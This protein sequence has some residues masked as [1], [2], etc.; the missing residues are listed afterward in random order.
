MKWKSSTPP[1][2]FQP[3]VIMFWRGKWIYNSVI[4]TTLEGLRPYLQICVQQLPMGFWQGKWPLFWTHF[5]WIHRVLST[6]Q[7]YRRKLS[8]NTPPTLCF[9]P[10][11][12]DRSGC[13]FPEKSPKSPTFS[14]CFLLLVFTKNQ[15]RFPRFLV[16]LEVELPD[17]IPQLCLFGLRFPFIEFHLD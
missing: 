9:G 16:I 17:I 6:I 10:I 4:P 3:L 15:P 14:S 8:Q 12:P 11:F 1:G 5:I 7:L 13:Q 2:F